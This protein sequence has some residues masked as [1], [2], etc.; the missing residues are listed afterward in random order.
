M[1]TLRIAV[2][3]KGSYNASTTYAIMDEVEYLGSM[4]RC[5]Q[6][7]TNQTPS[8]ATTYWTMSSAKG[9]Q[10]ATGPQGAAGATGAQGATGP[11]G[12]AG[13]PGSVTNMA[14]SYSPTTG[15]MTI[16]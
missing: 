8:T 7:G 6:A 12:A 2:V 15:I 11:Q 3:H 10:G 5:I 14:I 1:A 4:Y 13:A 9:A 16:V